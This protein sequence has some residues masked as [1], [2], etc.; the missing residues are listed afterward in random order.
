MRLAD[1]TM[2]ARLEDGA[3]RFP[4]DDPLVSISL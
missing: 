4:S 3:E 1:G 2:P